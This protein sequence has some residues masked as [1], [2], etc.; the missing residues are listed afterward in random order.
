MG[1]HGSSTNMVEGVGRTPKPETRTSNNVP[2][3][4]CRDLRVWQRSID[5]V[6]ASYRVSAL[7]PRYEMY[8]L[9]SQ[10]R[11]AGTSIPANIAEGYGT[12]YR[13]NYIRHLSIAQGSLTE[14]QT[15]F[16]IIERLA[17]VTASDLVDVNGL[18]D[19]VGR[20]STSLI[21]S[22]R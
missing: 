12:L 7:L 11:R 9:V 5:L 8:G 16:Y 1:G 19:H 20:M 18:S 15:H 2:L 17:Y 21:R 22:L 13:A 6:V 14:L 10:I 3:T 4:S